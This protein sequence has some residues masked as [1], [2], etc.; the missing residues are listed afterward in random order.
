MATLRELLRQ[1]QCALTLNGIAE[2]VDR[3]ILDLE[4]LGGIQC[5]D[6]GAGWN[7]I[8]SWLRWRVDCNSSDKKKIHQELI[9]DT[10]AIGQFQN[11][12]FLPVGDKLF[13]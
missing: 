4:A 2:H 7:L 5:N 1:D 9:D 11:V 12:L 6:K 3:L 13:N 8:L 10:L